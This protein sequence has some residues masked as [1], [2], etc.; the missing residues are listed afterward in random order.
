MLGT[1]EIFTFLFVMLGPLKVLAPFVQRTRGLDDAAIRKVAWWTFLIATVAI[2]VGGLL[3]R[4]L[5]VKWHV[6]IPAVSLT[7]GV[8]FFIVALRH[9]L[10]QYEPA[11][12]VS[13]EPLPANAVAAASRL[14][15][16]M[17]L[18]PYGIAAVIALL[19]SS[20]GVERTLAILGMTLLVLVLDLVAMWFA[21][22]LLVGFAVV[23]LQVLG[24]VLAVLQ[25]ALSVQI[26]IDS[27]RLLG[28]VGT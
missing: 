19:A 24:A 26:I 6:S 20:T 3:A 22:R 10:D 2:V 16:P 25:V 21:P 13:L 7:G 14:V 5:L 28:V 23:A 15:F 17:V 18:T 11:P 1:A 8:V 4:S 12:A 9:L 27:L